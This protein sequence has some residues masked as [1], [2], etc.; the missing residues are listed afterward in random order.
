[1]ADETQQT[2]QPKSGQ[3]NLISGLDDIS[4][5]GVSKKV[6]ELI[7]KYNT[8]IKHEHLL[9]GERLWLRNLLGFNYIGSSHKS[10]VQAIPDTTDTKIVFEVNNYA[11]NITWDSTNNRFIIKEP[12]KYLVTASILW[13][14]TTASK[15]YQMLLYKNTTEITRFASN[16]NSVAALLVSNSI[17]HILDLDIDDYIEIHAYH[18]SGGNSNISGTS[19]YCFFDIMKITIL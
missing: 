11:L 3:A 16:S 18:N 10:S 2:T 8:F 19:S 17:S 5:E 14:S 6:K 4:L 9:I 1:M 12:G 7:D 15:L 13:S